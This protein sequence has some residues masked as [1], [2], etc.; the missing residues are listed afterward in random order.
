M[1]E[2]KSITLFGLAFFL[3]LF[4]SSCEKTEYSLYANLPPYYNEYLKQKINDLISIQ[5]ESSGEKDCFIFITDTHDLY[6]RMNSPS[7]IQ[8]ILQRTNCNK[9]IWGGDA[10]WAYTENH[11]DDPEKAKQAIIDQWYYHNN[12]FR[13][14]ILPFGY[15]FNV[16][17]NHDLSIRILDSDESLREQQGYTLSD[18]ICFEE[19]MGDLFTDSRIYY[20]SDDNKCY[21]YFDEKDSKTRYLICDGQSKQIL[22]GDIAWGNDFGIGV[23]EKQMNWIAHYALQTLPDSYNL[24]VIMH[25]GITDITD[26]VLWSCYQDYISMLEAFANKKGVFSMVNPNHVVFFSGHCHNDL[27]TFKNGI[28]HIGTAN[29]FLDNEVNYSMLFEPVNRRMDSISEQLM[30]FV[31]LDFGND[32][33]SCIRIGCGYNRSFNLNRISLNVNETIKIKSNLKPISYGSYNSYGQKWINRQWIITNDIVTVDDNGL[34]TAL[35]KGEAVVFAKDKDYNKEYYYIV[36][37]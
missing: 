5:T 3:C 14:A 30:D 9:V 15:L 34:V 7:I 12:S 13:N 6:N 26:P 21:Y 35:K 32:R 1:S 17:G 23:N 10:I 4:F 31:S 20:N 16:R 19:L 22:D 37:Q 27:Q 25:E 2:T 24:V 33:L 8:A 28:L 29:D 36:V 18:G 11:N